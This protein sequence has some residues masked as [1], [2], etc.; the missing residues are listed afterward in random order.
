M[1]KSLLVLLPALLLAAGAYGG[2]QWWHAWRFLQ[3]TDDAYVASDISLISP[4][5]E[6]YI[7]EVRAENNQRVAAGQVLFVID[8]SDFKAKVAQASAVV[9]SE[10]AMIAT[11]DTRYAY[12]L[13]MISQASAAMHAA[14]A[15]V[16]RANLDQQRYAALVTSEVASR[17]RHEGAEA[18]AVKAAANLLKAQAAIEAEKQQLAVL[19]AQKREEEA[20]LLQARATL[21]LAQNDL[22]N[23]VIRAPVD[24]VVG[25]RAGQIGQYVKAGTQ[26][27][28]LVPLPRVYVTANFKETQLT[29]MRPGQPAQISVDAYPDQVIDGFVESFAPASGAEFSLLPPDNATG[30]FT[31]IVQR[32]PVRI[33][34]PENGP[35]ASL[36]RPGLSVVVNVDTRAEESTAAAG[37]IV[38]AAEAKP[39]TAK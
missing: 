14:E 31:K 12:Q 36:L 32:V 26:L 2:W 29:R 38:G 10:E 37:A 39:A 9:A 18:D 4:K 23:T 19:K 30:N 35:L 24:G 3:S 1:R 11:F 7:N 6:G 5:I 21:R 25:N 22:D 20:R 15:E 16:N 8:D 13:A 33:A 27:L 17:Q 28:S 34:V